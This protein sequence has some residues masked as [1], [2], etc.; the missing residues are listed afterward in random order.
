MTIG[1]LVFTNQNFLPNDANEGWNRTENGGAV[2][3]GM[4]AYK[5]S[6]N[7]EQEL[8]LGAIIIFPYPFSDKL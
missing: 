2:N 5:I 7:T 1:N 3:V 8:L 4:Y 6:F